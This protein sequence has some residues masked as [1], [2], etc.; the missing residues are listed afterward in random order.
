MHLGFIQAESAIESLIQRGL[1]R[2]AAQARVLHIAFSLWTPE[3][4][5]P[6]H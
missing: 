3:Q 2:S 5:R 1:D 4:C 6:A